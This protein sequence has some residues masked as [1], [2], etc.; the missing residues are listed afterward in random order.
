VAQGWSTSRSV[1]LLTGLQAHAHYRASLFSRTYIIA[2][3]ENQIRRP[4][5]SYSYKLLFPQLPCFDI[6]ANCPGGT[7][8]PP[9]QRTTIPDCHVMHA[10][11][12][13]Q[14][15]RRIQMQEKRNG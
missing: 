10:L 6:H 12:V 9:P 14:C 7:P 11:P 1:I 13:L 4:L 5:F 15:D 8:L 3:Q 2:P